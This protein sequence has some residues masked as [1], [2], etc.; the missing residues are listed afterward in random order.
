MTSFV[1][2]LPRS[3]RYEGERVPPQARV[4]EHPSA[5]VV[6]HLTD[7]DEGVAVADVE[8]LGFGA[9]RRAGSDDFAVPEDRT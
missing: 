9:G 7:L 6:S 8:T 1:V 3:W 5:A 4:D 2:A